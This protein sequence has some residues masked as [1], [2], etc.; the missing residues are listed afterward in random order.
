[1]IRYFS[2]HK[3]KVLEILNNTRN[4][5]FN[6]KI[7]KYIYISNNNLIIDMNNALSYHDLLNIKNLFVDLKYKLEQKIIQEQRETIRQRYVDQM[8]RDYVDNYNLPT[9]QIAPATVIAK[10][11]YKRPRWNKFKRGVKKSV[12]NLI[13]NITRRRGRNNGKIQPAFV[14]GEKKNTRKRKGKKKNKK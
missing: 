12:I 10:K 7:K 4:R 5:K 11:Y 9:A 3:Q 2:Q 14:V 1:M 13:K 8:L 6:N